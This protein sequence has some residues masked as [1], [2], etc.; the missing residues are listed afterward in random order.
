MIN[1]ARSQAFV[2]WMLKD[3]TQELIGRYGLTDSQPRFLRL[4]PG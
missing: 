2:E 1:A 3:S 4:I